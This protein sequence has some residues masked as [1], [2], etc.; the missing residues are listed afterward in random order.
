MTTL[1]ERNL[2]V[3]QI[4]D[5]LEQYFATFLSASAVTQTVHQFEQRFP[6]GQAVSW[7]KQ[8]TSDPLWNG[9]LIALQCGQLLPHPSRLVLGQVYGSQQ[10]G[11]VLAQ[12]FADLEQE[13]LQLLCLDTK[14]QII[15]RQIVF[16]GTLNS[17]PAHP[18]EIFQ[19]ALT[20]A[21]ARIVIAHNHPSG[22]VTPSEKDVEF[23]KRLQLAGEVIGIPL[24]DSFVVG[25]NDYFS[26]AEQGLLNCNTDS[27]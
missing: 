23:T 27:Q 11:A 12:D 9:L 25:V 2:P 4:H 19:V 3:T 26:F 18:R 8:T 10:I 24:L 5:L 16:Q 15:K 22:D 1:S 17:C 7:L 13:Q 20:T 21:T 6:P 14:N